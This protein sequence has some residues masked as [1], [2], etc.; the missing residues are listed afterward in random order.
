MRH[1]AA[2]SCAA[3]AVVVSA[4]RGPPDR[5]GRFPRPSPAGAVL[6]S[7]SVAPVT[8]LQGVANADA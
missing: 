5:K 2:P 3:N 1:V 8:A 4:I 6:G 7:A